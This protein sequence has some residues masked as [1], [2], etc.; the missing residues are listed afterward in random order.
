L[1]LLHPTAPAASPG[2]RK[3][4]AEGKVHLPASADGGWNYHMTAEN[5]HFGNSRFPW[6]DVS[7]ADALR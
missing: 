1:T 3:L 7:R 5:G 2:L 4:V 6:E